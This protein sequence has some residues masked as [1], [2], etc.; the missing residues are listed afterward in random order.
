MFVNPQSCCARNLQTLLELNM[1]AQIHVANYINV[2][3]KDSLARTKLQEELVT[4][5]RADP[6]LSRTK[7]PKPSILTSSRSSCFDRLREQ[8]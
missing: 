1:A 4:V 8:Y 6:N 5:R 3:T 2:Q 7:R